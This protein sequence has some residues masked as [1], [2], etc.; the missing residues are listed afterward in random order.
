MYVDATYFRVRE[1]PRYVTK[2]LLIVVG[3]GEDGYRNVLG[4]RVCDNRG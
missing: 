4:A 1:G 2:A 3:V